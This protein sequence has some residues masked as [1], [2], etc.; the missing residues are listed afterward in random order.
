MTINHFEDIP[1]NHSVL[2]EILNSEYRRPNDKISYMAEKGE[3]I[4]LVK[5]YYALGHPH[6]RNPY[7]AYN[8][9]NLIYGPSYISR[10]T[11]LSYYGFLSDGVRTIESMTTKRPKNILNK[12]GRFSYIHLNEKVFQIGIRSINVS[13]ISTFLMA[14][15]EKAICDLIW[16][17]RNLT[18]STYQDMIYFLEKDQR[19]D[20]TL[21]EHANREIFEECLE[22]GSRP[23][24]IKHLI[25]LCKEYN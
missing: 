14:S 13:S 16:T 24:F 2:H 6:Q 17:S 4:S 19:I 15:P 9:A 21:F 11:A 23:R 10:Y 25:R 7:L 1:I 3:L 8:A 5:G 18:F 20:M 22:Y 12:L